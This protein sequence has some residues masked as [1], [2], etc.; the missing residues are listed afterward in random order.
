MAWNQMLTNL[1]DVLADLYYTQELARRVVEAAGLKPGFIDLEGDSI[2]R[3]HNILREADRRDKVAAV[4]QVAHDEYPENDWLTAAVKGDLW[5]VSG[6]D[7]NKVAWQ[8]ETGG[9]PLEKIMGD[10]STLMPIHFLEVGLERAR[11]VVKVVMQSGGS[12]SGFLL[13]GNLLVTNHHVL[14]TAEMAR[15]ATILCN[16]QRTRDGLDAETQQ[17]PLAPNAPDGFFRT[18]PE[19][20]WTVVRVGGDANASY[21]ALTLRRKG[22]QKDDHVNIIQHPGGGPKQ[23]ALYHNLVTYADGDVVQYLTDTLPGSSG[24]P[25]FDDDWDV[26]A[27]HHSGGWLREPGVK[28]PL[29]RNE[30]IAIGKVIDALEAL[31]LLAT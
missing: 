18:S 7:I 27:L 15:T 22:M 3:W 26:V 20:D 21:G 5:V 30:G 16:Y 9:D 12:G 29:Y 31:G 10:K 25:V 6:A 28:Q 4:V 14:A 11:S 13:P 8:G 1:R 24:S 2:T 17:F 19:H 23:I